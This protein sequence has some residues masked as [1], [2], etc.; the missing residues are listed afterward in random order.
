MR[1]V[2]AIHGN[3]AQAMFMQRLLGRGVFVAGICNKNGEH[4]K[5][6]ET[7]GA[8][9]M[10]FRGWKLHITCRLWG[11]SA[12]T[13]LEWVFQQARLARLTNGEMPSSSP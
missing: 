5:I 7:E 13:S 4:R 10:E 8:L 1:N 9:R 12:L 6:Q 3:F 2:A 11:V